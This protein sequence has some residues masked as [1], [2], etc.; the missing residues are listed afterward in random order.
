[1]RILL[2]IAGVLIVLGTVL[3][4]IGYALG[5]GVPVRLSPTGIVRM[6]TDD[7][8]TTA[9]N[10]RYG[11]LTDITIDADLSTISVEEGDSFSLTGNYNSSTMQLD[12]SER[13][14]KLTVSSNGN[15]GWW[16][17]FRGPRLSS[18]IFDHNELVL[19]YPKG[20]ELNSLIL[21]NDLGSVR[22][23]GVSA[24][25]L[26]VD[27][28]AGS[29]R[30]SKIKADTISVETDLGSCDL[31]RLEVTRN[32]EFLLDAGSLKLKNATING[33]VAKSNLGEFQFSGMLS[34][35]A[36]ISMN[37]GSLDL[38]IAIPED[39][40]SYSVRTDLGSTSLNGHEL[41]AKASRSVTSPTLELFV[42]SDLGSVSIWTK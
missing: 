6:N 21:N 13:D 5:G 18:E 26:K 23:D 38:D 42:D 36:D 12:I 39:E 24:N 1:M 9:I 28:D 25:I 11:K 29:L 7:N 10:E 14:G 22:I 31:D 40:L 20:A 16:L 30:G 41:G 33:L 32:A 17:D 4:A 8:A 37:L 2:I 15:N 19:T 34:G 27:L 3:G 35:R